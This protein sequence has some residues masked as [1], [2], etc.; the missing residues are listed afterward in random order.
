[1]TTRA[2][3]RRKARAGG[4]GWLLPLAVVVIVVMTFGLVVILGG[5]EEPSGGDAVA[6][7]TVTGSL[8]P[9]GEGADPAV[10]MA[11]PTARG[12]DL[13]GD[14]VEIAADGRAK[15][16][17][18]LAH[19]C[20]HCRVEVPRVQAWVEE[21][22]VPEQVDLVSVVT[23]T[24]PSQPNYPPRAWLEREG[25][26]VPVLVDDAEGSV[27]EAYG[28]AAFPYWVFVDGEGRVVARAEGE[29]EI[30][31]LEQMLSSLG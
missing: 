22:G 8:P 4:R 11:V 12:S 1:M 13:D 16:I 30:E 23:G 17:V 20:S 7:V 31:E 27:A 19:W 3:R 26:S 9:L 15:G 21:G 6:D 18:F 10:G 25:W 28:L 14:P 29:L 2:Q 5:G 24:D